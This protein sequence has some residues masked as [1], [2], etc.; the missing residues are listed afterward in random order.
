MSFPK[1]M[2]MSED[3]AFFR[4]IKDIVDY[5]ESTDCNKCPMY[6]KECV[7]SYGRG[8]KNWRK[9]FEIRAKQLEKLEEGK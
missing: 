4:A 9:A 6:Y 8:P 5:C 7:L 2:L 3:S 1:F